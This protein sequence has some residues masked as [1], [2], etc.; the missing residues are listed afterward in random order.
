MAHG[1]EN[2]MLRLAPIAALVLLAACAATPEARVKTALMD[3]GLAEPQAKCMAR[4]M[5]DDLSIR[6]LMK[7]NRVSKTGRDDLRRMSMGEFVDF[8]RRNGDPE[9]ITVTAR[10]ALGCAILGPRR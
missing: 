8:V 3:Y 6:Q 5:V 1:M 2:R 9:L 10:A 7:L 4:D